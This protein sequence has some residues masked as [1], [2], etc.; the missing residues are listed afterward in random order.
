MRRLVERL[1]MLEGGVSAREA[2]S[3]QLA[4]AA[5][6]D[7]GHREEQ[8]TMEREARAVAGPVP[9]RVEEVLEAADPERTPEVRA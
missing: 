9:P 3:R 1:P 8:T 4:D 7:P 5:R 6:R 2:R